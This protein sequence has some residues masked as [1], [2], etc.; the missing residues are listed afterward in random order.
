MVRYSAALL[1]TWPI[2]IFIIMATPFH[3]TE[4]E[5]QSSTTTNN[6]DDTTTN[7]MMM[8]KIPILKRRADQQAAA[9][10]SQKNS[11]S[12]NSDAPT[13]NCT[14]SNTV[15]PICVI[16]VGMAGSGKTTLMAQLQKSLNLKARGGKEKKEGSSSSSSAA[17]DK[18][19]DVSFHHYVFLSTIFICINSYI[20][21]QY[22]STQYFII[23]LLLHIY[24]M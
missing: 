20:C 15:D 11:D 23:Y 10:E 22:T 6:N 9:A 1:K 3:I 18:K 8:D 14:K 12:N 19:V 17:E 5:L 13:N 7:Q 2:F 21:Y 16:V 4:E 24:I